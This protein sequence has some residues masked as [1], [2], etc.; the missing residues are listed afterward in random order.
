MI[1]ITLIPTVARYGRAVLY[2]YSRLSHWVLAPASMVFAGVARQA[3]HDESAHA[4]MVKLAGV[5]PR[6]RS[7][8]RFTT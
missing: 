2:Y 4:P 6:S 8:S 5:G 7:V 1:E 3:L